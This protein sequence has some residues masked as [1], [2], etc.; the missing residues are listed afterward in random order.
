MCKSPEKLLETIRELSELSE[1]SVGYQLKASDWNSLIVIVG[2]LA[3]LVYLRSP[4]GE[5][6]NAPY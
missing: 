2:Q 4:P 1:K 3:E 6:S 5:N